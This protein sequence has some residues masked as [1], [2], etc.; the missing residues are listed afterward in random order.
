M[1]SDYDHP[2][3]NAPSRAQIYTRIMKLSEGNSWTFN[4]DEFVKWDK[5]HPDT[6]KYTK[7]SV[8]ADGEESIHVAPIASGKT[9]RQVME[10]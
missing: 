5:A 1:F 8:P 9:W 4:Y 2:T 10:R 6:V 7:S 3:F